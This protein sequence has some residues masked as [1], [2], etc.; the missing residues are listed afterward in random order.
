MTVKTDKERPVTL[1]CDKNHILSYSNDQEEYQ[2]TCCKC[3]KNKSIKL[4]CLHC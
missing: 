2:D 3:Q 4:F 1:T